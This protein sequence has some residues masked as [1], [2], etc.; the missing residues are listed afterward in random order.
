MF[1][2]CSMFRTFWTNIKNLLHFHPL[3]GPEMEWTLRQCRLW[4]LW[5]VCSVLQQPCETSSYFCS[6]REF[7]DILLC[8]CESLTGSLGLHNSVT[9]PVPVHS[10]FMP[11]MAIVQKSIFKIWKMGLATNI[12]HNFTSSYRYSNKT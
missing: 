5:Q 9:M 2:W 1:Y 11:D 7:F 4:D 12:I 3:C 8:C 10:L 6:S